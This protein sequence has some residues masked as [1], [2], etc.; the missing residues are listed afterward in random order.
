[1]S[2]PSP[3]FRYQRWYLI[4]V[5]SNQFSAESWFENY[6]NVFTIDV[7]DGIDTKN[8][9]KYIFVDV[10]RSIL[11]A[12]TGQNHPVS[13]SL[14]HEIYCIRILVIN[15]WWS[16]KTAFDFDFA[17]CRKSYFLFGSESW[18]DLK[19]VGKKLILIS[20]FFC[21]SKRIRYINTISERNIKISHKLLC[22][23]PFEL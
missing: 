14:F 18:T 23:G 16:Q 3:K 5:G 2:V 21:W 15:R 20:I 6:Y 11:R 1:M 4:W 22:M 8:N 17:W 19:E 13:S 10:S 12:C 7:K 9:K